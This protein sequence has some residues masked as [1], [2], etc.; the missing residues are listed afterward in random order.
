MHDNFFSFCCFSMPKTLPFSTFSSFTTILCFKLKVNKT[1]I[2]VMNDGM[3][4]M[5]IEQKWMKKLKINEFSY[6]SVTSAAVKIP[7]DKLRQTFPMLSSPE[8]Q[9]EKNP[10][11]PLLLNSYQGHRKSI[12]GLLYFEKN[13]V[14]ISSSFDKSVRLWNLSGQVKVLKEKFM[15][16]WKKVWRN[17]W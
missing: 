6:S 12:S 8:N 3:F 14:L 13:Q 17:K 9:L 2:I 4:F 7:F 15:L 1:M 11:E 10:I 16:I 5:F